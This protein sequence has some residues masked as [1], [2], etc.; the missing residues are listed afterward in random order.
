MPMYC[1]RCKKCHVEF[2]VWHSMSYNDQKCLECESSQIFIIPSL[3]EKILVNRTKK[4]GKVVN[5]FIEDTKKEIKK[6]KKKLKSE[7]L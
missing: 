1:Y 7:V 3:T 2:E 6:E 4:P 5:N